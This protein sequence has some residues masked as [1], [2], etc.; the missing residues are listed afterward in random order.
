ML[1]GGAG[2]TGKA[3][4]PRNPEGQPEGRRPD[5]GTVGLGKQTGPGRD[6]LTGRVLLHLSPVPPRVPS[7]PRS[8]RLQ[9]V[10][11]RGLVLQHPGPRVLPLH[12]PHGFH[13]Q[14]LRHRCAGPRGRPGPGQVLAGWAGEVPA[15]GQRCEGAPRPPEKCFDETRY[16]H[17]EVGDRWAR[18]SQ[19]QV[20]QCECTGGQIRCEGARHTGTLW[21]GEGLARGPP[22]AG[23]RRTGPEPALTRLASSR[24]EA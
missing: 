17:L 20:E 21:P 15:R 22:A 3:C 7:C 2:T 18:V 16:E 14:G 10:P 1:G 23:T 6:M 12:L 5:G 4:T 11:Q 13:R 24:P 19:G 9:P 8:L